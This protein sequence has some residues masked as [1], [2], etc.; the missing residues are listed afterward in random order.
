MLCVPRHKAIR[1][2]Y[3]CGG[4]AITNAVQ[5]NFWNVRSFQRPAHFNSWTKRTLTTAQHQ[6]PE[7]TT[8]T[9]GLRVASQRTEDLTVSLGVWIDAGSRHEIPSTNG[10]AHFLEHL[11]TKGTIR[12][13]RRDIEREIENTGSHLNAYTSREQTSYYMKLLKPN[14]DAAADLL[15]DILLTPKLSLA[16]VKRERGVI[17]REMEEVYKSPQEY[18]FDQLHSNAFKGH[19][20]GQTILGPEDNIL[21]IQQKDLQKYITDN[22][23]SDNMVVVAVGG[24]QHEELVRIVEDKFSK[25]LPA[26][27][28]LMKKRLKHT[29]K[30]CFRP[31]TVIE[32]RKMPFVS[33]MHFAVAWEGVGLDHPDFLTMAV[34]Q[35]TISRRVSMALYAS[36]TPDELPIRNDS[37]SAFLISADIAHMEVFSSSYSDTGLFGF[38][39]SAKPYSDRTKCMDVLGSIEKEL[40]MFGQNVQFDKM[41]SSTK[42]APRRF[43]VIVCV[44]CSLL[45]KM[46]REQ[47]KNF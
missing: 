7:I 1:T 22:Y 39:F 43:G 36:R 42:C 41:C 12:R 2:L 9:N 45:L 10:V 23:T 8:L 6:S 34:L 30:P 47:R 37:D 24:V 15:S 20:L 4:C 11:T 38:Y 46:L 27:D 14:L 44:L 28:D 5:S 31:C 40:G 35:Q 26:S 19:S 13:S 29:T 16:D 32:E 17:L 25:I 18:I 33:P 3:R 21:S